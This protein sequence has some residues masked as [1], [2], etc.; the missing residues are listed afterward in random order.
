MTQSQVAAALGVTKPFVCQVETGKSR[1]A[2]GRL[3]SVAELLGI[4]EQS[5]FEVAVQTSG[6]VILEAIDGSRGRVLAR[7]WRLWPVLKHEDLNIIWRQLQI[8]EQRHDD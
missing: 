1:L 6:R 4:D 7:L 8:A 5:L 3:R 2:A